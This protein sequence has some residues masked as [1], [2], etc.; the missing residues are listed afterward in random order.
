MPNLFR[1]PTV[2]SRMH[3]VHLAYEV[4]KQVTHDKLVEWWNVIL[5]H[6]KDDVRSGLSAC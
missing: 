2:H 3:G 6:S 1:Q 4:L 5:R